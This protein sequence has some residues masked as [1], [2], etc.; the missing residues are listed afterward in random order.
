MKLSGVLSVAVLIV[1][2]SL[3]AGAVVGAVFAWQA[4][5][6]F[7][8]VLPPLDGQAAIDPRTTL[9]VGAIGV[10][11]RLAAVELRDDSGRIVARAA[12]PRTGL[13][14]AT[15][16]APLAFGTH[17]TLEATAERPWFGQRE[18]RR[19]AFSTVAVPQL[20]GPVRRELPADGS[21]TLRFDQ[22]VGRIEAS[23]ED[24]R[25]DTK[26]GEA[27]RAVTLVFRDY[28]QGRTVPVALNWQTATGVPL[29]PLHLEIDTP[30][31]LTAEITNDGQKDLGLAMPVEIRFSEPLADRHALGNHVTVQTADGKVI[32]GQW[33]WFG[34]L[35]AQFLPKPNWPAMATVR[36]S[37][38]RSGLRTAAGGMLAQPLTASFNTGPDKRIRVYLDAQRAE[39]LENG[40]VVKTF[41]VSTGKAATPTVTGS[42]Y[43][44][45]RFP[46]K[47]MRSRAKP[48]EK[49]HYVVE[50]VPY[51]QY[52]HADYAFHG[53]F[54]HNGFGHPA[55]HGCVNLSTRK[56]NR[57]W[58]NAPED[59]GW[60]YQWASLGVP[61]TVSQ[62]APAQMAMESAPN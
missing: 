41:K 12:E 2:L 19:L 30:P 36:V 54:W 44:Y 45:A 6:P 35:R 47:T 9:T 31:A 58:P 13:S 37:L 10:G 48:G 42:F 16:S 51:A 52:F 24:L 18:T 1:R 28:P 46:K 53:A 60:L 15:L 57:R 55:S 61:V 3:A 59:A 20:E 21:I 23:G 56:K 14:E 26:P 7:G 33:Q 8:L 38:D 39:A 34:P 49:G 50:D 17:Y 22:P 62:R 11:S 29:P 43:I 40:Q 27:G 5:A 4:L 25:L 32:S